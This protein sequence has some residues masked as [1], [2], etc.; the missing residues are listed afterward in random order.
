MEYVITEQQLNNW[1][2]N[3][4]I[5]NFLN[6]S[7]TPIDGFQDWYDLDDVEHFFP[8]SDD[9]ELDSTDHMWWAD[10]SS[11][12]LSGDSHCPFLVI[13]RG[14]YGALNGY[15][16]EDSWQPILKSWFEGHTGLQV[17]EISD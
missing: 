1:K 3:N 12:Y 13:P 2:L 15:F 10:C 8:L 7:L 11:Q 14:V 4:E 17:N 5:I 9:P 16:G 6:R